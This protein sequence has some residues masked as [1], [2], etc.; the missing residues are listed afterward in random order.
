[1]DIIVR[2]KRISA[3]RD[4]TGRRLSNWMDKKKNKGLLCKVQKSPEE[5]SRMDSRDL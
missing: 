5:Y 2:P 1:M 3:S 4:E